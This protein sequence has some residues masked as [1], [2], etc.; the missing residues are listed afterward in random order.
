MAEHREAI[1]EMRRARDLLRGR[2]RSATMLAHILKCACKLIRLDQWRLAALNPYTVTF[3]ILMAML[4][5]IRMSFTIMIM[6]GVVMRL[7]L[8]LLPVPLTF[9]F[10]KVKPLH[11]LCVC[12]FPSGN[13]HRPRRYQIFSYRALS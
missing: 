10:V 9:M 12:V 2:V 5:H 4:N 13:Y 11:F 3:I 8:S 6:N 1:L 7:I